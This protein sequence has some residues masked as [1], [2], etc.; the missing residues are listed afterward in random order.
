[1]KKETSIRT[2]MAKA[3]GMGAA[4]NGTEHWFM[5]RVTAIALLFL[6]PWFIWSMMQH[7][8][9]SYAEMHAWLSYPVNA[10]LMILFVVT[11]FYHAAL[12]SQV[13]IEDYIH[14]EGFK[15]VKLIGMKL[16]F[17]ATIVA[18]VFAILKVAFG[19]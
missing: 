19:G 18:C 11:A 13:V 1:M 3:K 15:M 17:S 9:A 2:P 5:Q 8:G 7:A 6:S 4:H 16:F 12:G 14:C 10:V